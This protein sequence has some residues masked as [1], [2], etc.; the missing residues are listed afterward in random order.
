MFNKKD[1]R[2]LITQVIE[3]NYYNCSVCNQQIDAGTIFFADMRGIRA[4]WCRQRLMLFILK[5]VAFIIPYAEIKAYSIYNGRKQIEI[6]LNDRR[7]IS[8]RGIT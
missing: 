3:N 8:I 5:T 2:A 1:F 4:S 6:E 7:L